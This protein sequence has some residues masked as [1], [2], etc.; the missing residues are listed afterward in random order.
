M[1]GLLRCI[2][3]N[4]ITPRAKDIRPTGLAG[5]ARRRTGIFPVKIIMKQPNPIKIVGPMIE[6]SRWPPA[7]ES[8][9]G[10]VNQENIIIM[11]ARKTTDQAMT[12][13]LPSFLE[14]ATTV[15]NGRQIKGSQN[16]RA[17]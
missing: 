15:P 14:R 6:R 3:S 5:S 1:G 10:T 8:E 17:A 9:A 11:K 12:G 4:Q 2:I 16:N 7:E 13:R